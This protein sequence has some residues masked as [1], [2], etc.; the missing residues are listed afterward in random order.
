MLDSIEANDAQDPIDAVLLGDDVARGHIDALAVVDRDVAGLG[1]LI[2]CG[3]SLL[4]TWDHLSLLRKIR[5]CSWESSWGNPMIWCTPGTKI[6][7]S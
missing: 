5:G 6:P 4:R 2:L 1:T 7:P 3:R